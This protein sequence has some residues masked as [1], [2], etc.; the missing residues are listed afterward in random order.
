MCHVWPFETC[1]FTVREKSHRWLEDFEDGDERTGS[2][3]GVS[4]GSHGKKR[5]GN[6]PKEAVRILKAWLYE[7]RYNAYPTDQE[8][9][10]LSREADLTVLQVCNWFIN[11][12]RRILPEMIKREGEDP[13]RYTITRK[14]KQEEG[15]K[16]AKRLY[17]SGGF[18]PSQDS[19]GGGSPATMDTDSDSDSRVGGYQR[20]DEY[21]DESDLSDGSTATR[22]QAPSIAKVYMQM[23]TN[24]RHRTEPVNIPH[25]ISIDTNPLVTTPS[26]YKVSHSHNRMVKKE[27]ESPNNL[28][29]CFHML[30]DVAMAE[31][32]ELQQQQQNGPDTLP[33][34]HRPDSQNAST[35]K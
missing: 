24:E 3:D 18:S 26:R 21:D 30:V 11:A 25:S 23:E 27:G 35:W 20:E 8:K 4:M 17:P 10:D 31:L 33:S 6:L 1:L 14:P 16:P 19:S 29:S 34:F 2:G 9:L 5:R 12:R 15:D 32:Q 28:F 22:E 13:L 7:H